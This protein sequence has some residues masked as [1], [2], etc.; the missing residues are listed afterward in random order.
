[1]HPVIFFLAL[2]AG[3]KAQSASA[4]PASAALDSPPSAGAGNISAISASASNGFSAPLNPKPITFPSGKRSAVYFAEW[5]TYSGFQVADLPINLL[6]D[7]NYAFWVIGNKTAGTMSEVPLTEDSYA[8]FQKVFDASN[9][10]HHVGA[11]DKPGQ[12]Y[13]GNFGQFMKLRKTN[14]FNFG[15]SIG[16][17]GFS[18]AMTHPSTFVDGIF[19]ALAQFPGLFN[20]MDIDWEYPATAIDATNFA[21]FLRILRTRLNK[22]GLTNFEISFAASANPT[23][24]ALLPFPAMVKNLDFINVMTYDFVSSSWGDAIAGPQSNVYTVAPYAPFSVDLAVQTLLK[25]GVPAKMINI[26]VPMY[27]DINGNTTGMGQSTSGQ[28]VNNCG[29]NCLYNALPLAGSAEFW[30][31]RSKST[32]SLDPST[33]DMLTYDSIYSVSEKCQYVW[34]HGLAGMFAWEA[35]GDVASNDPRSL[36]AAMN[37]CLASDPRRNHGTACRTKK[38]TKGCAATALATCTNNAWVVKDCPS[39]QVCQGVGAATHCALP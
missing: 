30:D 36:I 17:G 19:D 26:G 22:A 13:F 28:G 37:R 39:G 4:V 35:S 2:A 3:A 21:Q 16:G 15:L 31:S 12:K 25:N 27:S 6:T 29:G 11:Y 24:L 38:D 9:T 33:G 7:V 5:D 34:D 23:N 10:D 18:S 32:Y 8:D 20:R 14:K 1:M